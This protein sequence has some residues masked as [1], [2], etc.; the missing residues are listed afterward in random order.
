MR[1]PAATSEIQYRGYVIHYGAYKRDDYEDGWSAVYL[2]F[3]D[4]VK[5]GESNLNVDG[6][7]ATNLVA[8]QSALYLAR[9][10]VEAQIERN[11]QLSP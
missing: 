7:F 9:A 10:F 11:P 5:L 2:V 6:G 3:K 8:E 4:N 1:V